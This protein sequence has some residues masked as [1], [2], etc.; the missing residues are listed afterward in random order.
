MFCQEYKISD[1]QTYETKS[2][3]MFSMS[4]T[5]TPIEQYGGQMKSLV[6]AIQKIAHI[7]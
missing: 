3:K 7:K 4:D 5:N 2:L 1:K 6:E